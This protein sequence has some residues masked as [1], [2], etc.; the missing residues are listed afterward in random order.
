[1]HYLTILLLG[2][3]LATGCQ[4]PRADVADAPD[5]TTTG[6]TYR[7]P[8]RPQLHFSPEA[9]WMNDPNGMVYHDGEYHL[10][11]Q[12]YPDSTVWGPM[13]WGHAVTTDL[14]HWEHL[15][16]ALY[17]DSLGY[18]FSGSAVVDKG[19]TSGLGTGGKDPLVAIFTYHDPVG[20]EAGRD[21]YERQAIAYSNDRGRSWTKYPGNPVLPNTTG[22]KDF[23]DPKVSWNAAAG[24]WVMALAA[25]DH[26]SFYGSDNLIDWEFLSDFGKDLG[27]HD[28]VWECPDL[29]PLPVDGAGATRWVLIVNINP[30]APYG[31]SGTQYFVGDFDGTSFTVDPGFARDV[32]DGR[33]VWLD[34]GRDNYAGVT[35][36]N[37]PESDGRTLFL[38]W[39]S[40]WEYANVVPTDPW[41]SAMTLPRTLSLHDTP[42]GLR[43]FSQPVREVMTLRTDSTV[44]AGTESGP[45]GQEITPAPIAI[46]APAEY[47]LSFDV[48]DGNTATFGVE[49]AN[50]AGETYRIGYDAERGEYFSDR[51]KAGKHDFSDKFA[52]GV[53]YAPRV[54]TGGNVRM[55]L[56]VDVSGVELFADGGA[57]VMTEL[58]FPSEPFGTARVFVD[59]QGVSLTEGTGYALEGVWPE[60]SR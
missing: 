4:S 7:E 60:V 52:R 38:G 36:A 8:Y 30:G 10:F 17:P 44:L 32:T 33:G 23:R 31:G 27:G 29:F 19:N 3:L 34:Y 24:K 48:Q 26:I 1:M 56:I 11:Y 40:N 43:V 42:A 18:I 50:G 12:Y 39:M 55:H 46:K 25:Q 58:F 41:R 37:V 22:L 47:V 16:I 21:D 53:T 45:P 5:A 6:A 9:H 49:L 51:T 57:T 13:H 35:W 14:L 2:L 15:P 54:V 28:G 59:G 20:A